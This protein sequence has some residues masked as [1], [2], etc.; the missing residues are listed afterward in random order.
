M[1]K[2]ASLLMVF[3]VSLCAVAATSETN[4][5]M[6][7]RMQ[8]STNG[9]DWNEDEADFYDGDEFPVSGMDTNCFFGSV[10]TN[11]WGSQ[12]DYEP[13]SLD[14]KWGRKPDVLTNHLPYSTFYVVPSSNSMPGIL[15][16]PFLSITNY[17]FPTNGGSGELT[18][19]NP[20]GFP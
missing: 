16:R 5:M 1:N 17:F 4:I 7:V 3:L 2:C 8:W 15:Y 20:P 6:Y 13:I 14:N 12:G 9:M 10:L 19:T 18:D 11:F